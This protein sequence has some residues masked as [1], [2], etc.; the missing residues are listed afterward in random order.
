MSW[1][2]HLRLRFSWKPD[3]SFLLV[4]LTGSER[5]LYFRAQQIDE[6]RAGDY[7]TDAAFDQVSRESVDRVSGDLG[8]DD[9]DGQPPSPHTAFE[10]ACSGGG[11]SDGE[12]KEQGAHHFAERSELFVG[13]RIEKPDAVQRGAWKCQGQSGEGRHA[14]AED[15][16]NAHGREA[17]RKCCRAGSGRRN[18]GDTIDRSSAWF[19]G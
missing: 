15:Q 14:G 13:A 6:Q 8:G 4:R 2:R 12:Q 9:R 10:P 5:V 18:H 3:F 7:Y 19:R 17:A 1:L 11:E 16:E